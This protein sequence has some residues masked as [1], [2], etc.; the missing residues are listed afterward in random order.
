MGGLFSSLFG[1]GDKHG[2]GSH[3]DAAAHHSKKDSVTAHDRA[4]LDL[5]TQRDKIT[6]FQK[7][8][9]GVIEREVQ[10]AKE[11][12]HQGKKKEAIRV[13][14][15]KKYQEQL[16]EKAQSQLDNVQQMIDSVEFAVMEKQVF[17]GLKA[18]NEVL[19]AL[20]NEM[21]VEQVETLMEETAEAIEYQNQIDELLAGQLTSADNVAIEEELDAMEVALSMPSVPETDLKKVKVTEKPAETEVIVD[22]DADTEPTPAKNTT[23]KEKQLALAD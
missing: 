19:K 10:V 16:L 3:D 15:K 22:P 11:L 8:I 18:G 4:I 9:N 7:K 13:L 5:K 20:N 14:K 17:D 21:S 6:M 2:G 23:K 12:A 1:G